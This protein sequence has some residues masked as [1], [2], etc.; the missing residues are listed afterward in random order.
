MY[1][2]NTN[3]YVFNTCEPQPS[4]YLTV[5]KNRIK[6]FGET[7]YMNDG[8]EFEFELFN[9]KQRPVL[10]KIKI[11]GDYISSKGIYLKPGQRIFLDRFIDVNKKFLFSTYE[12]EGKSAAVKQAIANNGLIEL[13]F[14]DEYVKPIV[15]TYPPYT[16]T[17]NGFN[18]GGFDFNYA[19]LETKYVDTLS[20]GGT[21]SVNSFY[22]NSN[23]SDCLSRSSGN[24]PVKMKSLFT[25]SASKASKSIETGRVEAGNNSNQN[26]SQVYGDFNT[27]YSS[28]VAWK[29]LPNS[30]K[31]V[32]VNELRNFCPACGHKIKNSSFKFCP[33]CGNKL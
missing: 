13:E 17:A 12:V 22:S 26:F 21:C 2:S 24:E 16:Y 10:V 15:S 5:G 11:N 28:R 32:E 1:T 8:Q 19:G 18:T 6:Q 33:N 27:Y 23:V 29:I 3:T 30:Q 20:V 9:P 7:V 14:Y 25:R 31:P 4:G